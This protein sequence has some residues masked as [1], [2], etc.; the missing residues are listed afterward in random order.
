[1][2]P[3]HSIVPCSGRTIPI[4][5]R[6]VVVFP[7]P[8]PAHQTDNLPRRDV[9]AQVIDR[10]QVTEPVTKTTNLEHRNLP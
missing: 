2:W 3:S 7:A 4:T 9:E 5:A 10:K 6:I 1:V 8:F